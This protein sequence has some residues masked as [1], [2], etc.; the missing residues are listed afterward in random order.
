MKVSELVK[1]EASQRLSRL[2][3]PVLIFTALPFKA[4]LWPSSVAHGTLTADPVLWQ[5][6]PRAPA[7][8]FPVSR[9]FAV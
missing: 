9:H 6:A 5:M 8:G 2:N 4:V 3:S 1:T 7:H